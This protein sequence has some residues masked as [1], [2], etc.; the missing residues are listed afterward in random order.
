LLSFGLDGVVLTGQADA[1]A[2]AVVGAVAAGRLFTVIDALAGPGTLRFEASR[3][4][5]TFGA[6]D[7]IEPGAPLEILAAIGGPEDARIELLRDGSVVAAGQGT[8]LRYQADGSPGVYR[9]EIHLPEAPGSPPVPW[10]MSN[11]LYVRAAGAAPAGA[12]SALSDLAAV[13]PIDAWRIEANAASEGAL[14]TERGLAGEPETLLRYA[15]AGRPSE[16]PYVAF[17][18]PVEGL[19]A[20]RDRLALTVRADRPLRVDI[21]VRTPATVPGGGDATLG[22]RWHRSVWADTSAREV[23]IALD[24]LLPR[25]PTRTALPDPARIEALLFVLDTVNTPAG[26]SGRIWISGLRLGRAE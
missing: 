2:G 13:P 7:R 14:D 11:P 12:P 4:G 3:G 18:V 24:E 8:E 21:Q 22:E 17:A 23:V 10:M 9:V 1:D 6:G 5:T 25:G 26:S 20:A 15:V 19:F 16:S